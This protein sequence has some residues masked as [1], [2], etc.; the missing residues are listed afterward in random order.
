MTISGVIATLLSLLFTPDEANE[1]VKLFDQLVLVYGIVAT[2]WGR[3]RIG[4][5]TW[6]GARK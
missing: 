3:Y 6:F 2:Y 1:F 4:D 5:I